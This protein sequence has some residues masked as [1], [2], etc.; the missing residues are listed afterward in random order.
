ME[1][2]QMLKR[3]AE[4][5]DTAAGLEREG[6]LKKRQLD[7]VGK[8]SASDDDDDEF[9]DLDDTIQ[10]SSGNFKYTDSDMYFDTINRKI[11]D[12]DLPLV[13]CVKLVSTNV[14]ICLVCNRYLQGISSTSPAYLHAVD[15]NH[16]IFINTHT[17]QFV[18]LPEQLILSEKRAKDLQD[19]RLLLNPKFDVNLIAKLDTIPLQSETLNHKKYDVGFVSLTNDIVNEGPDKK[20]DKESDENGIILNHNSI[21]YTI[22]H[23]SLLRD[24]LISHKHSETT[25]LLNH[26]SLLV[27]KIWSTSLFKSFIS[28]LAIENYL[29]TCKS[30]NHQDSLRVF[31]IWLINTLSKE[32][33]SIKDMFTGKLVT[34][35]NKTTK[36][37]TF[38]VKLP[39]ESLFK[40]GSSSSIEQ[41]DLLTLIKE[42]KFLITKFPKY[43][44]IYIDRT[45]EMKM[46][47]ISKKLN[48]SIVKFNPDLLKL[49]DNVSYRLV[50]NITCEGKV[51]VLDKARQRWVEYDSINVKEVE[52]D[53]LFISNGYLQ[54]WERY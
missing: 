42:K 46:E 37:I 26:L 50:A 4:D 36:F 35:N 40:D 47:G 9:D 54:F 48:M 12:F 1:I 27:R 45:N 11:L 43:L 25:P 2:K 39:Q 7:T 28:S 23:M 21:Y 33:K 6:E 20:V 32:N 18:I 29:A 13:C 22:A 15:S 5:I 17:L 53:L 3:K 16:H 10:L 31:Y 24:Y 41:H 19:I 44:T 38:T 49:A 34:S 51:Q 8:I 30:L 52:K 14:H